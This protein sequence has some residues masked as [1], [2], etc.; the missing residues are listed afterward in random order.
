M[1]V[2]ELVAELQHLINDNYEVAEW[3]VGVTFRWN[4]DTV[5]SD[6]TSFCVNGKSIQLNE[7]DFDFTTMEPYRNTIGRT[8]E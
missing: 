8:D 5:C 2:C 3:P 1:T 4:G 7:G 6:I